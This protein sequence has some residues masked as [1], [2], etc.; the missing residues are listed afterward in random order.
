MREEVPIHRQD[1]CAPWQH[2]LPTHSERRQA[3]NDSHLPKCGGDGQEET[4]SKGQEDRQVGP[5]QEQEE[6]GSKGQDV[7]Q[8]GSSQEQEERFAKTCWEGK[9]EDTF[10]LRSQKGSARRRKREG[11]ILPAT[12]ESCYN[13]ETRQLQRELQLQQQQ[14]RHQAWPAIRP[15]FCFLGQFILLHM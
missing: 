10:H 5:S 13:Q 11:A 7:R 8:A 4:D 15:H 3:R 2:G 12:A 9:Q 1:A 14:T 6:T